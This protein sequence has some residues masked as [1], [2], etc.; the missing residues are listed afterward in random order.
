VTTDDEF[1][2]QII[3]AIVDEFADD[4]G[5]GPLSAH[6]RNR[7]ADA[8]LPVI[9]AYTADQLDAAARRLEEDGVRG[10]PDKIRGRADNLRRARP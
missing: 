8:L 9:R 3:F 4:E 10:Y 2:T 1:R 6:D 7:I 5:E